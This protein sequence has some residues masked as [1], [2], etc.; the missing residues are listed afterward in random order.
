MLYFLTKAGP[1]EIFAPSK[2]M[3]CA[4]EFLSKNG[5]PKLAQSKFNPYSTIIY[6]WTSMAYLFGQN[7]YDNHLFPLKWMFFYG[8]FLIFTFTMLFLTININ[9]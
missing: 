4:I 8:H 2:F 3:A 9:T 7:T 1:A 6:H 5:S